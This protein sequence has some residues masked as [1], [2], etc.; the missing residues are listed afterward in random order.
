M[1]FRS[2]FSAIAL[3]ALLASAAPGIR[4]QAEGIVDFHSDLTLESDGTLDVHETIRV[5]ATGNQIRHG[6]YRDFP[7]RYSDLYG[8][9]YEV[10]FEPTA[11]TFDDSP[12]PFRVEDIANGK[13]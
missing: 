6:I 12:V 8:N 11:A 3:V 4:R 1:R 2:A 5:Y 7:A 10:G 9:K 13:R